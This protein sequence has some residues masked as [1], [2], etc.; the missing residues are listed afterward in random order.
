LRLCIVPRKNF[1]IR[2]K[3]SGKNAA[4]SFGPL[5]PFVIAG[6]FNGDGCR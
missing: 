6:S 4:D 3:V 1:G 2:E 5:A